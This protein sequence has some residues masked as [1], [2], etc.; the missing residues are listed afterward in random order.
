M[1]VSALLLIALKLTGFLMFV[2]CGASFLASLPYLWLE[3]FELLLLGSINWII[4]LLLLVFAHSLVDLFKLDK[5]LENEQ[6]QFSGLSVSSF[7][8]V[9]LIVLGLVMIFWSLPTA[10]YQLIGGFKLSI[11][12]PTELDGL[13]DL[14][15]PNQFNNQIFW[16]MIGELIFGVVLIQRRKWIIQK[17]FPINTQES[18]NDNQN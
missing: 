2:L 5:G 7:L 12:K 18:P 8:E 16:R 17:V 1:K 4:G 11:S 3:G 10:V 9:C 6:V 15:M 13:F 14:F